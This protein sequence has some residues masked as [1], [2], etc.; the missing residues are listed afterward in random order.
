MTRLASTP[1]QLSPPGLLNLLQ[2]KTG[3]VNPDDV[4]REIQ[5]TIDLE[6]WWLRAARTVDLTNRG[7]TALAGV[8]GYIDFSPNVIQVPANAWW[9]VHAYSVTFTVAALDQV[10]GLRLA[11]LYNPTGTQR[12]RFVGEYVPQASVTST[13]SDLALNAS[14]LWA[15]PGSRLGFYAYYITGPGGCV[16][17]VRGLEYTELPI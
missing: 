14:E 2:L 13:T 3:G 16:A 1:V 9:Y 4:Q 12:Y 5:P 6:A 15:P 17:Q 8:N 7:I 10:L 11:M